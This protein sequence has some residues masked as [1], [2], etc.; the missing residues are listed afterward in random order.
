MKQGNLLT[1]RMNALPPPTEAQEQ[2]ALFKRIRMFEGRYPVLSVVLHVPN[3]GWRHKAEAT[4]FS[5]RGVKPGVPDICVPVQR[6]R[7]GA[8]W[9]ELKRAGGRRTE[10]QAD[11]GLR[12]TLAGHA[13]QVCYS[14]AEAWAAICQYLG[15]AIDK[16]GAPVV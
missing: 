13:V 5:R 16:D 7:H 11:F 12:L 2:E 1:G 9:I 15:I 10:A 14:A 4:A 8:L 3:G 6:G